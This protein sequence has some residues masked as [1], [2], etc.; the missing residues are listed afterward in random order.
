MKKYLDKNNKSVDTDRFP[1][2]KAVERFQDKASRLEHRN[3]RNKNKGK[4][5]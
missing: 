1:G 2:N 5:R 4:K 3:V